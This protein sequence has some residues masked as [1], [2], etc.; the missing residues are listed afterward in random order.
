VA[1]PEAPRMR[2]LKAEWWEVWWVKPGEK[3]CFIPAD[4]QPIPPWIPDRVHVTRA[5][6][7]DE[8]RR[9]KNRYDRVLHIRRYT[10]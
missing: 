8:V 2:V 9:R 4:G 3:P 1:L 10:R 5:S 7:W 6:A